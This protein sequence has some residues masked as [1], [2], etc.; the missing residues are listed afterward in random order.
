[1]K[2][3]IFVTLCNDTVWSRTIDAVICDRKFDNYEHWR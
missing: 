2:I 3:I 1:M